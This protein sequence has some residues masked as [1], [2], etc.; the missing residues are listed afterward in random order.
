MYLKSLKV[1]FLFQILPSNL[2]QQFPFFLL[3]FFLQIPFLLIFQ[4]AD[5]CFFVS[6]YLFSANHPSLLKSVIPFVSLFRFHF[7]VYVVY[8]CLLLLVL[9][10]LF[11][12][13]LIVM[14][15]Q[16]GLFLTISIS[17]LV[18]YLLMFFVFLFSFFLLIT[19]FLPFISIMVIFLFIQFISFLLLSIYS[20]GPLSSSC[21]ELWSICC[22]FNFGLVW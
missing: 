15:I 4:L 10:H 21:S 7:A 20:P 12:V 22:Y 8:L 9:S 13:L 14:S 11:L 17:L 16:L 3:Q 6:D 1:T 2:S 18:P 5:L 19:L